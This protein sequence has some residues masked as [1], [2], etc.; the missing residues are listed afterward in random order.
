MKNK[1]FQFN[2]LEIWQEGDR[3]FAVYDAGGH[4]VAMRKDEISKDETDLACTGNEGA[5]KMLFI[6]QKRLIAA[7]V[8][9][10]ST[11]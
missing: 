5:I 8:N 1:L 10:Y 2:D 3:Y 6:L 7:G 11:T 4:Q 9:P